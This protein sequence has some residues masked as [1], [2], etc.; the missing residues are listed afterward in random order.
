M[1]RHCGREE[2]GISDFDGL[3]VRK[4]SLHVSQDS[5]VGIATGYGLDDGSFIPGR[6]KILFSAASTPVAGPTQHPIQWVPWDHF[7][8]TK[9]PGCEA[10]CSTPFS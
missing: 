10:D 8:R 7:L 9:R 6:G 2:T 4:C 3:T 5:S 1:R